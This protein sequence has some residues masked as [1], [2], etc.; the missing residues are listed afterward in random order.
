MKSKIWK[1]TLFIHFN[2]QTTQKT[3]FKIIQ[4][5]L[6]S[7]IGFGNLSFWKLRR[8][9]DWYNLVKSNWTKQI[10]MQR[11]IGKLMYAY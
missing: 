1:L 6:S 11:L 2:F 4:K 5:D 9:F 7:K 10:L 8:A 3:N